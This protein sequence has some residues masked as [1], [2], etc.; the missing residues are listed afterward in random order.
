MADS[1]L[2]SDMP[3]PDEFKVILPDRYLIA[4]GKVCVQWAQLESVA[5]VTIQKI[6][7]FDLEDNRGAIMTAHL[8]WTLRMDILESLISE[9]QET[10]PHLVFKVR[11]GE[12]GPQ[13]SASRP[14]SNRSWDMGGST[15][16]GAT[17]SRHRQGKAQDRRHSDH[18]RR[19]RRHYHGYQQV[20][21]GPC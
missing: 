15:R 18:R 2:S 13:T 9:L 19:D 11:H 3:Y 17:P 10:Y 21:S 8:P 6:A 7:G 12:T 5:E 1:N 4:V 16:E 14:Q 20:D